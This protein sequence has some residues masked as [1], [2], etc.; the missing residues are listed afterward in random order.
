MTLG[1]VENDLRWLGW[2]SSRPLIGGGSI[3]NPCGQRVDVCV[4]PQWMNICV[5]G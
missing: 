3:L 5:N 1:Q 4:G 2:Q